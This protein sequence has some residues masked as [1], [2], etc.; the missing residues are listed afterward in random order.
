MLFFCNSTH[1]F[2]VSFA[3]VF[4]SKNASYPILKSQTCFTL[5]KIQRYFQD[6]KY[7]VYV[8]QLFYK[9]KIKCQSSIFVLICQQTIA[10][11]LHLQQKFEFT[12]K[13]KIMKL[14]K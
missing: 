13:D 7:N 1:F 11:I 2:A 5:E 10:Q 6:K 8:K 12:C 3:L 9:T 4:E 14:H